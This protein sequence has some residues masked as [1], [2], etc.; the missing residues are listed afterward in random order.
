MPV[1]PVS[2]RSCPDGLGIVDPEPICVEGDFGSPRMDGHTPIK[3]HSQDLRFKDCMV[4]GFTAVEQYVDGKCR[5][6]DG[7]QFDDAL[8]QYDSYFD[9]MGYAVKLGT[10]GEPDKIYSIQGTLS[11]DDDI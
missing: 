10:E 9:V 4:K 1:T 6:V 3:W 2:C 11:Y 8:L 7:S 5:V